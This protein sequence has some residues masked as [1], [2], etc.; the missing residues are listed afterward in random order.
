MAP[1]FCPALKQTL[2]HET[3]ITS[4]KFAASQSN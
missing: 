2:E 3:N 1:E 4:A